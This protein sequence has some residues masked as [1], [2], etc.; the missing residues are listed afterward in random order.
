MFPSSATKSS[1][2]SRS[3]W[4]ICALTWAVLFARMGG[5]LWAIVIRKKKPRRGSGAKTRQTGQGGS[6]ESDD[7]RRGSCRVNVRAKAMARNNAIG[8][9]FD[10]EN[11]AWRTAPPSANRLR[12]D[13]TRPR[14]SC[15]TAS[16]LYGVL[17]G[18][19]S[20]L[21]LRFLH[22]GEFKP[23]LSG[24]ASIA[25]PEYPTRTMGNA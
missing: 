18:E 8:R 19:I 25:L 12:C 15:D 24:I 6:R 9:L 10:L 1:S 23:L 17:K 13:T 5:S 4:G 22:V 21:G 7:G 2:C 14:K 3:S 20:F 11:F 16:H